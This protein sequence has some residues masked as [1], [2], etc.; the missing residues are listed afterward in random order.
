MNLRWL[1]DFLAV[2]ETGS[3]TE[4][5]HSRFLTQSTLSKHMQA[6]EIWLGVGTLLDR[7]TTP[8]GITSAGLA[9][10]ETAS[11]IVTL[12]N[13]ARRAASNSKV[14]TRNIYTFHRLIRCL[15]RSSRRYQ[16]SY[17][18]RYPTRWCVCMSLQT[19]SGRHCR[20]TSTLNVIISC[21]MTAPAIAFLSS[22]TNT[23]S[24][25]WAPIIWFRSAHQPSRQQTVLHDH[26]RFRATNAFSGIHGRVAPR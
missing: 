13:S 20:G 17:T 7:S 5:A 19:T 3:F 10:T 23:P 14:V 24:S 8:V 12:L 22:M 1:E 2:C 21:A 25:H 18:R 26:T 11:Q 16:K 9:F 15:R 4:A 6:L